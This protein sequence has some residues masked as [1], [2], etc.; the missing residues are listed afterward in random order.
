MDGS[1]PR[2]H[3]S[4]STTTIA[5]ERMCEKIDNLGHRMSAIEAQLQMNVSSGSYS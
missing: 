5:I 1:N 3:P 2:E 4:T